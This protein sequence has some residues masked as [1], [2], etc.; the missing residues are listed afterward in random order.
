[1][2]NL[3]MKRLLSFVFI[4]CAAFL[5]VTAQG[6]VSN[7]PVAATNAIVKC[8]NARFTVLTPEMIRIEYSARVRLRI[9]QHLRLSIVIWMFL[10][11]PK[12]KTIPI[13]I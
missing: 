5:T 11:L 8:G 13:Y 6:V 7:N 12:L 4:A 2:N 9:K 1:M 10:N 3:N